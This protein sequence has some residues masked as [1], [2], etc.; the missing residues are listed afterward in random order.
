M[1]NSIINQIRNGGYILYVKHAEATEGE[2]APNL[3]IFKCSTQRLLSETGKMQAKE[4]GDLI[5]KLQIPISYPVIT[6]PL[7]RAIE[8]TSL[9]FGNESF[10]VDP[11]WYG[12][13]RLSSN[14]STEEKKRILNSLETVLETKLPQGSNK[15][16]V[17]HGFPEG[18]GL[19]ELSDMETVVIKPLGRGRGYEV[20]GELSYDDLVKMAGQ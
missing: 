1:D 9:A 20:V 18:E 2:D 10:L 17:A 14:P 3:N 12:V 16:I 5:R 6:S 7:C 8:T 11:F 19:G 15:L 4:Y 13:N